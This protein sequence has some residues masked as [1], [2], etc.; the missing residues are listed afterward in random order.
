M[1]TEDLALFVNGVLFVH[2]T[3]HIDEDV[4]WDVLNEADITKEDALKIELHGD[5]TVEEVLNREREG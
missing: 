3:G 2:T 5:I 1:K 4:F